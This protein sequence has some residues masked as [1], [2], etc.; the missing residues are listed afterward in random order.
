MAFSPWAVSGVFLLTLTA[1]LSIIYFFSPSLKISAR[2]RELLR[3]DDLQ[4]AR[5]P[6]FIAVRPKAAQIL[7]RNEHVAVVDVRTDAEW[8][9]GHYPSA[10]HVP[11]ITRLPKVIPDRDT[12]L[13][14]YCRTGRRAATAA[15]SA[16]GLG[17]TTIYYLVDGSYQELEI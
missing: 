1:I 12:T 6:R 16:A 15:Q 8:A 4:Q 5:Q 11:Q 14:I 17:Y 9:T 3:I 13:L 7:L 10:Y 2:V